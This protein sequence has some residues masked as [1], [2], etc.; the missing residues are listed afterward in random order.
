MKR[1]PRLVSGAAILMVTTLTAG[2]PP[3]THLSAA[4][5]QREHGQGDL[6]RDDPCDQLPDPP[7]EAKGIDKK[8]A[9]GGS[10]S[11]IAKG[12]FNGDGFAD[13]A[14]GVPGEDTPNDVSNSGAV[15][16]IYGSGTAGLTASTTAVP[17]VPAPQFWSQNAAGVPGISEA[18]DAFGSALAAGDFNA[19]GYSD[20]AI[21]VPGE[22]LDDTNTGAV[23]V[24]Y[25]SRNGL[26]ATDS[27]VP[28][29][30]FFDLR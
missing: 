8:C 23:I 9:A 30:R 7:G 6:H 28:A 15:N 5:L 10:S 16:V 12:D 11:G 22:D 4:A 26:T 2:L 13:L 27:S 20:L 25:G 21:G 18:G 14:V 24:I 3:R 19:D 29:A 1:Y 17:P